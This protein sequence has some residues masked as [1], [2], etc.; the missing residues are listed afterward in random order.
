MIMAI[1]VGVLNLDKV[2]T[3][4]PNIA[5][6]QFEKDLSVLTCKRSNMPSKILLQSKSKH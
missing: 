3:L 6:N 5:N 1:Y 2:S 4:K